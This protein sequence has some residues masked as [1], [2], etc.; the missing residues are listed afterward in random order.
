M[1]AHLSSA[2]PFWRLPHLEGSVV[3]LTSYALRR[4]LLKEREILTD[5]EIEQ[6]IQREKDKKRTILN[7][8]KTLLREGITPKNMNEMCNTVNGILPDTD[9]TLDY[10]S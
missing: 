8:M 3:V 6:Q 2:L 4:S 7:N 9:P 1:S 5:K 10:C